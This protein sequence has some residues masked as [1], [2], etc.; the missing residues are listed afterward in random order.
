M[1][2]KKTVL[3]AGRDEVAGIE[4]EVAILLSDMVGYSRKTADMRPSEIKDF[5]LLYHRNLKNI[6]HSV[7][8]K[9][10]RIESSAGD[11]AVALISRQA[12]QGKDQMCGQALN[13]AL[14]MVYAMEKGTISETRIGLFAGDVIE[15]VL[16]G[17]T[18]RFGASFS[19]ASRLE[20]LCGYFGVKILMDREMA[21]WQT[22][23]ARY[24]TCIGKV[25][26]KN[27]LHPIHI[28]SV[29]KPGIHKVPV[30]VNKNKLMGFIENKNRAIELFCGNVLQGIQPNFPLARQKLLDT[31]DLFIDLTGRKDLPTERILEYIGNHPSP[32]EDFRLVGM[33][34]SEPVGQHLGVRL[35]NLSSE[36]LKA[37]NEAM[38]QTL[39]V[40]T[41]WERKFKLVW[42][43][44][45]EP[46]IRVNDQPDGV[47][48]I[49]VGSVGIFDEKGVQ[50]NTLKA[51]DV[52]GEM[53]YF[54]KKGVRSATVKALSDLVLR[55]ISGEDLKTLPVIRKIFKKIAQKRE[56]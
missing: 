35:L 40:D 36:F 45:S 32:E 10:Q 37:M 55:R 44:K 13:V 42:R 16:D 38:Y 51:G 21:F 9:E 11:G 14:E 6:V 29:Y 15:A 20:E 25:T 7:C 31:Q 46:I 26:P 24:L 48:F 22:E 56:K 50:I 53:A 12:G 30:D 27:F 2:S 1:K 4:K 23:H 34:I 41:A 49:D 19:V 52:F 33:K 54:S 3:T 28:F 8:G 5:M 47:Y 43:K 18:M 17:K 39:V